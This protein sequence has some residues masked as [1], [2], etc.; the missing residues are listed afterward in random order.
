MKQRLHCTKHRFMALIDALNWILAC[1]PVSFENERLLYWLAPDT[2]LDHVW[3]Y[4]LCPSPY[5]TAAW[6]LHQACRG[7]L[8][9]KSLFF[10]LHWL[11]GCTCL[12]H[13]Y[14]SCS[15]VSDQAKFMIGLS[16]TRSVASAHAT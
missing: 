13:F 15:I 14:L 16:E 4:I 2:Y 6:I 12:L 11:H 8:H 9:G 10:L 1:L 7:F 5:V 3:I